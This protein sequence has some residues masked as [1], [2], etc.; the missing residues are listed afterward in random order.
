MIALWRETG[1]MEVDSTVIRVPIRF[2]DFDE[3]WVTNAAGVGPT[4]KTIEGLSTEKRETLRAHMR[5]QL[6]V[7]ADGSIAYEAFANA[8]KGR[9]AD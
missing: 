4:G 9:V 1:L 2:A 6:A 7:A 3:F 8:V 5:D